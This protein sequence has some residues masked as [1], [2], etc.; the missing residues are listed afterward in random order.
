MR[1]VLPTRN[2][3]ILHQLDLAGIATFG[4]LLASDAHAVAESTTLLPGA[5]RQLATAIAHADLVAAA[6]QIEKHIATHPPT[7]GIGH[8]P[9]PETIVAALA[10]FP[11]GDVLP[12]LDRLTRHALEH[13]AI[14]TFGALCALTLPA[15]AQYTRVGPGVLRDITHHLNE[16]TMARAEAILAAAALARGD[17]PLPPPAA[18]DLTQAIA[19]LCAAISARS[20]AII[21]ARYGLDGAAPQTYRALSE[22]FGCS[23]QRILQIE[24]R[25]TGAEHTHL[26]APLR[27]PL[28]RLRQVVAARDGCAPL[29]AVKAALGCD[30]TLQS[31]GELRLLVACAP[32]M[33]ISDEAVIARG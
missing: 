22:R 14:A 28:V 4:D 26:D 3:R 25:V 19:A 33:Q 21:T 8:V 13:N 15:L 1:V 20:A 24:R 31:T 5:L 18:G 16:L 9:L 6:A 29:A 10:P 17:A 7:I 12:N 27:I 2:A 32:G 11:I 30:A 23:A